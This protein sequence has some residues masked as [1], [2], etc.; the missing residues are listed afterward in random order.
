MAKYILFLLLVSLFVCMP[1]PKT[2]WYSG[3]PKTQIDTSALKNKVI[4]IDPGH[5]GSYNGALGKTGTKEKDINLRVAWKL[6]FMLD[7]VG[8]QPIM[9]RSTDKD[10]LMD[11]TALRNVKSDLTER[12]KRASLTRTDLFVSLHHNSSADFL[13]NNTKTF[14]AMTDDGPSF[15]SASYIHRQLVRNLKVEDGGLIQGNYFVL[16]SG[17]LPAVLGEPS[18]LS[19]PAQEKIFFSDSAVE[20]EARAYF[21]GISDFF[22]MQTPRIEEIQPDNKVFN[23]PQPL[24][25]AH[26]VSGKSGINENGISCF[27][28]SQKTQ[29]VFLDKETI[30]IRPLFPLFNGLHTVSITI[31]SNNNSLSLTYQNEFKISM[32]PAYIKINTEPFG[33]NPN[34]PGIVKANAFIMDSFNRPVI[35]STTVYF[36]S[37]VGKWMLDSS[38]TYKGYAYNYLNIKEKK[39]VVLIRARCGNILDTVSLLPVKD[40]ANVCGFAKDFLSNKPVYNAQVISISDI[41]VPKKYT[42]IYGFFYESKENQPLYLSKSGYVETFID[43]LNL[44]TLLRP[45]D[46]GAL[47]RKKILIDPEFGGEEAGFRNAD[48]MRSA[49]LNMV[50]ARKLGEFLQQAGAEADFTRY[51]NRTATK[52]QRVEKA[53][54]MHADVF[55]SI[56]Y[57]SLP[58]HKCRFYFYPTSDQGKD[59]CRKTYNAAENVING[60]SDGY[61]DFAN[62]VLQQTP[63]P[64]FRV[65]PGTIFMPDTNLISVNYLAYSVYRGIANYF[66]KQPRT[67][68]STLVLP[69]SLSK[70]EKKVAVFDGYLILPVKDDNSAVFHGLDASFKHFVRIKSGDNTVFQREVTVDKNGDLKITE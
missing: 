67:N 12:M 59:L 1:P 47:F 24:L 45:V 20:T 28:D 56:G 41:R 65:S 34:N 42:D 3:E 6:F 30:G 15:E 2:N 29:V 4:V 25:W 39:P 46:D 26:V 61:Y 8:A 70:I 37:T 35:D 5:G 32:A 66:Q 52:Y 44:N 62:T 68:T 57:D 19:N 16:H 40:L 31:A 27:I 54:N 60:H 38:K 53:I 9:T 14:Y 43:T 63:C 51:G 48:G 11:T 18:Y 49:D 22:S 55:V 21:Q 58:E 13:K 33:Y 17:K 7:S 50:F 23:Y 36:E 10:F 64:A 69:D